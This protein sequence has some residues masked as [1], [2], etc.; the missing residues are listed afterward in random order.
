MRSDRLEQNKNEANYYDWI[1]DFPPSPVRSILIVII[2]L[3]WQNFVC[4]VRVRVMANSI[5]TTYKIGAL[6]MWMWLY[7]VICLRLILFTHVGKLDI[8]I[9]YKQLVVPLCEEEYATFWRDD[10]LASPFILIISWHF[11]VVLV[12]SKRIHR[13]PEA[14]S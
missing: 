8:I 10:P 11:C 4:H 2:F 13:L 1:Y 3:A 12:R 6:F 5:H 9:T 7:I 14:L